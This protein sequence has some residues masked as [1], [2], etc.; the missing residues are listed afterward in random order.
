M[1]WNISFPGMR[2]E[3]WRIPKALSP[4]KVMLKDVLTSPFPNSQQKTQLTASSQ[5]FC[6]VHWAS[7]PDIFE[8]LDRSHFIY[9][10][11]NLVFFYMVLLTM[12]SVKKN[13]FKIA[14]IN[15]TLTSTSR[16]LINDFSWNFGSVSEGVIFVL[17]K[18]SAFHAKAG[19]DFVIHEMIWEAIIP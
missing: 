19:I 4:V 5:F 3:K 1:N 8:C 10:K 12:G 2:V 9:D 16:V 11:R 13:N 17:W 14:L 15:E 18:V 6:F 7:Q